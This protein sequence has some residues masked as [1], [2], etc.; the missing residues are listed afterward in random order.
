M[1]EFLKA[2]RLEIFIFVLAILARLIMFFANAHATGWDFDRAVHGQ[3][4]YYEIA[5]NIY[6]GRGFNWDPTK[7]TPF[8][9]PFLPYYISFSAF[10]FGTF[11]PAAIGLI[12]LGSFIPILAHRLSLRLSNSRKIAMF[13]ALV[14][15]FEPNF[16]LFSTI[17]YTETL[18][19][20]LFLI[21]T[22]AFISYLEARSQKLACISGGLLG[23]CVL[24][25]VAAEFIPV[26]LVPYA[27]IALRKVVSGRRLLKHAAL[28]FVAFFL[29]LSPW[30][31]RNAKTFG[32][33]GISVL[34]TY[35]LY[36]AFVPSILSMANGT[37]YTSEHLGFIEKTGM[38]ID[39][40]V[41]SNEA[42]YR[43]VSLDAVL[44]HTGV[45]AKVALINVFTFFTHDNLITLL[46]SAGIYP[47]ARLSQ[48]AITYVLSNPVSF[49]QEASR[50]LLTPFVFVLV[51]RLFWLVLFALFIFETITLIRKRALSLALSFGLVLV[52]YF[53]AT[54]PS[55]GLT[56][57]GRFRMPIVPIVL[58]ISAM[59]AV[60]LY[61]K[62]KPARVGEQDYVSK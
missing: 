61:E 60:R 59:G 18:F 16:V 6:E 33:M 46:G 26:F 47:E 12:V 31:Y 30:I 43:K 55:N 34:P 14:L 49:I 10:L 8:H 52:L 27:W 7:P 38:R 51:L 2:Y 44:P 32:A 39:E 25:K 57:N 42:L 3:D 45:I 50:F 19:V 58:T 56:V 21:F 4:G 41:F 1:K 15:V 28:F 17:F 20:F 62:W 11:V 22:L 23:L 54:T 29:V 13:A 36:T 5:K 53:A 24:T 37:D 35:N 48:P 9:V 40:L